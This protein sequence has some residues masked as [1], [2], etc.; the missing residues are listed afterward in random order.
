MERATRK[1][2]K[3][4]P[5]PKERVPLGYARALTH[6]EASHMVDGFIPRAMEDRWFILFDEDWLLFYR[7]WTGLCIYGLKFESFPEG[8]RVVDSW[9][10]CDPSQ[11]LPID[12]SL[13]HAL[14]DRLIDRMVMDELRQ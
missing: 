2:W 4:E 5:L 1:S 6:I 8:M 11:Y 7:S 9:V 14:L 13:E 10:N 12:R 3:R